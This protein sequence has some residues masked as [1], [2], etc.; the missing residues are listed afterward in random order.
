MK[1]YQNIVRE[2]P[3]DA[4]LFVA[5]VK[6]QAVAALLALGFKKQI[7][8][9]TSVSLPE[10]RQMKPNALLYWELIQ[11]A[12]ERGYQQ[13]DF[14]R[15]TW[16]SGTFSFKKHMGATPVPLYY[17]YFLNRRTSVPHIHQENKKYWLASQVWRRLPLAVTK[18]LGPHLIK[19]VV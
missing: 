18:T 5:K 2:F 19:Y 13:L 9:Y 14:G 12:C 10:F 4:T 17:D 6:Q 16:E 11:Y 1:F 15:S 8:A 3:E 7:Q